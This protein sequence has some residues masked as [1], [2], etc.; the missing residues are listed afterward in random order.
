[1]TS[2]EL[3]RDV[4]VSFDVTMTLSELTLLALL[5][6]DVTL[7]APGKSVHMVIVNKHCVHSE[8]GRDRVAYKHSLTFRVR[9]YVVIATKPVQRLQIRPI[10]HN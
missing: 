4:L 2:V 5:C 9:L 8:P 3:G 6:V 1:M 7:A 10:L